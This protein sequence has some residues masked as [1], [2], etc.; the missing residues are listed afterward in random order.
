MVKV[1]IEQDKVCAG[2]HIPSGTVPVHLHF[3]ALSSLSR[4]LR[5]L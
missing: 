2:L 1:G 3:M 4:N 5:E